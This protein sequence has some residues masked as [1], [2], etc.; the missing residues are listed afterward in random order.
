MKHYYELIHGWFDFQ[1]IYTKAVETAANGAH[2]VEIGSWKGK[3]S[4]YMAVEIINSGKIIKFD[5]VD[6]WT[7]K[8]AIGEYDEDLD[9]KHQTLY[10]AFQ[11]NMAPVNGYFSPVRMLSTDAVKKYEDESLDFIFIDGSHDYE[12]VKED[13]KN[14]LPKLKKGGLFAGHDYFHPDVNRAVNE[15]L[16]NVNISVSSWYIIK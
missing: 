13:I 7:G 10:E 1:D 11:K 15:L 4:A 16:E 2:F 8:G 9:V 3:S 6:V 5:C 14:W 12:S